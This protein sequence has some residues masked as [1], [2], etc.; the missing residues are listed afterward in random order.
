MNQSEFDEWAERLKLSEEAK[1]EIQRIRQSPPARRVGGGRYNV[2]GRYS[3]KK[4][5]VTIQ[6]ES[7]KVELP[8]IYMMEFNDDVLEY[9]DQ[10]PQIKVNYFQSKKHKNRKMAYWYT[11]DFFVIEKERAY[12]VEWKTEEELVKKSQ[13]KPDRYYRKDGRWEFAP[14]KSYAE[15]FGLDFRVRSSSEINWILQRNLEF[16]EDYIIKEYVPEET[17]ILKIKE[18]VLSSP[19]LTLLD[20]IG[21][22][23]EQFT[24]D[25]IYALIANNTIYI[26]LYNDLIT[27]PE[28]VTVYLNK[29]QHKGFSIVE[30][31]GRRR[32]SSSKIDLKNGQRLLWGDTVWKILHY[33]QSKKNIILLQ[34]GKREHQEMP[35]EVFESLISDGY[36]EG[37]NNVTSEDDTVKELITQANEKDLETANKRYEVVMKVL[38]GEKVETESVTQR[39]IRN[40]VKKYQDAEELYGNGFVGLL[41]KTKNKGNRKDKLPKETKDL[42]EKMITENYAT[43][44][45]K[46]IRE[47]HREFLVKCEELNI[48][49]ASYK[50][51]LKSVKRRPK[52]ELER[53]RKG[54]RAAYQYEEFYF[55]LEFTTP[56]HGE[57]IFNIAHI[58]HTELDIEV[59]INGKESV[60]PWL[61]LMI[62]A[63]SRRILAY[64]LTFEEP[65]YRSCMMVIRKCVKNYNRLPSYVVVDGGKEFNSVYFESLLAFY[66]VHKK[67][68]PAAKARFGNVVE[69]VFGIT[70]KLF[71][72]NLQGNTQLTKNVRQVTKSV[73][74]KNHAVWTLES[75]NERIEQ[76]INEVYDNMENP[77]LGMTPKEAYEESVAISGSRPNTYIPYN[78]TFILMTLPSPA[79]KTR[80]VHPGRGIKLLYSYYWCNEFRDPRIE[81]TN[82]EVKYDPFNVGIAYAFINNKWIKCLSE[83]FK[84]LNGKTEK[85]IQIIAEEIR[86][87]KS[88]QSRSNSITAK[89]IAR[90][91]MESELIEEKLYEEK[92][93]A[94]AVKRDFK[95]VENQNVVEKDLE[96]V[97]KIKLDEDIDEDELVDYGELLI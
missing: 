84:Y 75:L 1:S 4:M 38:N 56:K 33:D 65:S 79:R 80:K 90:F 50:A 2:S 58:D 62:D 41:P 49:I 93:K 18:A 69:R 20:L 95:V 74:P 44:K 48:P 57:R 9:Y 60:R 88:L 5:G 21:I 92:N 91:I 54:R 16:L 71:I 6:F 34:D 27:E 32:K 46:S 81:N 7:H 25:D 63:F 23:E 73:N 85:Q 64:Y 3:S 89:M 68:R 53:A 29:E 82:V 40:W 22:G 87:K 15:K 30:W 36:I 43:I 72:H 96:G 47:V 42:M 70:N 61:T 39:T 76:W 97:R 10:P 77:S 86:K 59:D 55:E 37:I 52:Y 19:G 78:D 45:S 67:E 24:V 66:G 51:F 8:A 31:S 35:L 11:A 94:L 14:G 83:E 12:W 28:N 26:D 13:E 17:T